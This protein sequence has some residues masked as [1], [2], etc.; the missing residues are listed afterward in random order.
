MYYTCSTRTT[1]STVPTFYFTFMPCEPL[2]NT[3]AIQSSIFNELVDRESPASPPVSDARG[4]PLPGLPR[5]TDGCN[6][7]RGGTPKTLTRRATSTCTTKKTTGPWENDESHSWP[8]MK[9][10][11]CPSTHWQWSGFFSTKDATV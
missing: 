11:R 10:D 3:H 7:F 6:G 8:K 4:S 9:N 2:P 5:S 1:Y